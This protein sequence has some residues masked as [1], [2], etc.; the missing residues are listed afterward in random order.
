MECINNYLLGSDCIYVFYEHNGC[1]Q[2]RYVWLTQMS[3]EYVFAWI[4]DE[5]LYGS[6]A[7]VV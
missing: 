6:T 4:S 7:V 2:N 5:F 1:A 3:E